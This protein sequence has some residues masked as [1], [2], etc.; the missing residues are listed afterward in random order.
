MVRHRWELRGDTAR[1]VAPVRRLRLRVGRGATLCLL[2]GALAWIC[3]SLLFHPPN[4][5]GERLGE[6]QLVPSAATGVASGPAAGPTDEKPGDGKDAPGGS[7]DV[8]SAD[9]S[10]GSLVVHVAGAV[11][12]PGVYT[13]PVGTR[14][15]TAV[16]EAGG[17]T[18]QADQSAV[19]LASVLNDGQ[20]LLIPTTGDGRPA[21]AAGTGVPDSAGNPGAGAASA[22]VAVNVNTA[23]A[24]EL[25]SLPG[26]GPVMAAKIIDHRGRNGPFS[27]LSEL[28]SVPGIGPAMMERLEG[29]VAFE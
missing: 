24:A 14:A 4:G 20:Q 17:L 25:E 8:P 2:L 7:P 18:A 11:K 1:P 27:S 6:V 10:A 22:A 23:P 26:V 16:E 3:I 19:N 9:T 29:L 21:G 28:D 15:A 12:K 13:F 5:G